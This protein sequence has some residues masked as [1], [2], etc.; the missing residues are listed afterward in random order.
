MR[1]PLQPAG[2]LRIGRLCDGRAYAGDGDD[3]YGE[4]FSRDAFHPRHCFGKTLSEYAAF[5]EGNVD[6]APPPDAPDPAFVRGDASPWSKLPPKPPP[7]PFKGDAV[8]AALD[9]ALGAAAEARRGDALAAL[10]GAARDRGLDL[11]RTRDK[12]S[13]PLARAAAA[14]NGDAV[15]ALLAAGAAPTAVD[16]NARAPL[17]RCA[18]APGGAQCA[19]LLLEA[20]APIAMRDR[21]EQ[22]ALHFCARSG[23]AETMKVLAS[24]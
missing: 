19:R 7:D 24:A 20:G 22:S 21:A 11:S 17:H 9:E 1:H 14:A 5:L 3:Y 6:R 16:S 15:A 2:G 13:T 12:R 23:D 18:A 8:L 10:L 4:S